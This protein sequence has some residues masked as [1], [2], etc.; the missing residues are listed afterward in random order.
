MRYI[1]IAE[2]FFNADA[3]ILYTKGDKKTAVL[4]A[5]HGYG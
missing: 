3:R 4:M 5:D 2:Y 1:I